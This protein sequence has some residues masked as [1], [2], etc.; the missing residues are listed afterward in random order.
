MSAFFRPTETAG[1]PD[2][3]S[4][5]PE[6]DNGCRRSA[7]LPQTS[8]LAAMI[9]F[10]CT[11]CEAPLTA[12]IEDAG[13]ERQCSQ[14]GLVVTVPAPPKR[15]RR[16]APPRHVEEPQVIWH[17]CKK[18]GAL[19]QTSSDMGGRSDRCPMCGMGFRVP[20]TP[21]QLAKH[22]A[23]QQRLQREQ[24]AEARRLAEETEARRRRQL[25]ED[26][27]R[28]LEKARRIEQEKAEARRQAVAAEQQRVRTEVA[29]DCGSLAISENV[30]FEDAEL[31]GLCRKGAELLAAVKDAREEVPRLH[32]EIP[33]IDAELER[34]KRVAAEER[35]RSLEESIPANTE[36][37][38]AVELQLGH[39]I[40]DGRILPDTF[41]IFYKRLDAPIEVDENGRVLWSVLCRGASADGRPQWYCRSRGED[42]G[43]VTDEEL[44]QWL[45]DDRLRGSELV[46]TDVMTDWVSVADIP[47]LRT[48][49]ADNSADG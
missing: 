5:V 49:L 31:A 14:C 39:R 25:A 41:G 36:A 1:C 11:N 48:F 29:I 43:P 40:I 27:R 28:R 21:R 45:R 8:P 17:A 12:R 3:V 19:L 23:E 34:G 7:E 42:F 35:L 15:R 30:Q 10:K 9:R 22:E 20:M 18:C 24:Q 13:Q 4:V 16:K 47:R 32:R 26:E 46:R 38:K 44:V 33:T 2:L 37:L 6:G